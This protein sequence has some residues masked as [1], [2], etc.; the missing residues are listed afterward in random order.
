MTTS[1]LSLCILATFT[2][3]VIVACGSASS[4]TGGGSNQG[5][6]SV[7]FTVFIQNVTNARYSDY[8]HLPTTKVQNEQAFEEMRAHIL[9]LYDGVQVDSTYM[10]DG[11]YIDCIRSTTN[12]SNPPGPTTI[13]TAASGNPGGVG[14]STA[15]SCKAGTIPMQRLTLEKLVTYPTLQ[16]FL[17]KSPDGGGSLPPTPIKK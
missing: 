2:L 13:G 8:A 14:V 17:S 6:T 5:N 3:F 16:A 11:Q 10:S 7:P 1:K 4:S 15:S 12:A 9:K